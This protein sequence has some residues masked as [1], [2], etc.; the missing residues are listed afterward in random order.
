M[1][2]VRRVRRAGHRQHKTRSR[3]HPGACDHRRKPERVARPRVFLS[4]WPRALGPLGCGEHAQL[5]SNAVHACTRGQTAPCPHSATSRLKPAPRR[6]E[7]VT[8]QAQRTSA[9][10][11]IQK[12]YPVCGVYCAHRTSPTRPWGSG[13]RSSRV[14][15]CASVHATVTARAA[16]AVLSS[17]RVAAPSRRIRARSRRDRPFASC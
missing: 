13:A 15:R 16:D 12:S 17:R 9:Q 1:P 4:F 8:L 7:V 3:R 6:A 10:H 5:L 2:K 14:L 11:V